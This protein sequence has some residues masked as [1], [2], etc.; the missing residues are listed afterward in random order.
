MTDSRAGAER[1][2]L[3][4]RLAVAG[5]LSGDDALRLETLNAMAGEA[6][7]AFLDFC[8]SLPGLLGESAG[9]QAAAAARNLA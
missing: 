8:D 9:V 2:A 7:K 4:E 6:R 5:S 3:A 1:S